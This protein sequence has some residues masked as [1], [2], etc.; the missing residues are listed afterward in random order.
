MNTTYDPQN[1]IFFDG[2]FSSLDPKNGELISVAFI[3]PNGEELYLEINYK[4]AYSPWVK[5]NILPMLNSKKISVLTAR[6][7]IKKFVG[8]SQPYLVSFVNQ[9]DVIFLHK[10]FG[11]PN[12]WPF[13]WI[14]IDF[15]SVLFAKGIDPEK[16]SRNDQETFIEMGINPSHY[17]KHHALD[18][19]RMLKEIYEKVMNYKK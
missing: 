9:F 1:I 5:K 7:K 14:P 13:H 8:N 6:R 3:K 18:D 10:F 15:A 12:K 2:E 11:G 19:T 16:I 17:K 4:G